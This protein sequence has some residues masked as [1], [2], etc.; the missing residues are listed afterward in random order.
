VTQRGVDHCETFS[1]DQDRATYIRLVR[2]N[3]ADAEVRVLG[4]C[5]M[6]NHV[7]LIAVPEREDSLAV[8]LRRVHGRYAQYYN[9]RTGRTGHLWQ[10]RFFACV[11]GGDHLWKALQY[12]E[13]NPVRAGIVLMAKGYRWSSAA[14]HVRGV[15]RHAILDMEWWRQQQARDWPDV[16]DTEQLED[17][18]SLRR[19]T[20][21]G[22]P[23]GDE[24]FVKQ[25]AERFG[26]RWGAGRPRKV[27][28]AEI[29]DSS[30]CP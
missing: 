17:V 19:C 24:S 28:A 6:T 12:V 14:D 1:T 3:L 11:L 26:R 23:F 20:Y 22:K 8:W 13:R 4:W 18:I 7:H 29:G 5:L 21:S 30:G 16:L 9:T 2:E 10:N 25:M 15:D 27:A